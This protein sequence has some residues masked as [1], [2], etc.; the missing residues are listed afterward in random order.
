MKRGV[1]LSTLLLAATLSVTAAARQQAGGQQ[2]PRVVQVDKLRDNLY[3]M[4]GG[5]GNSSVFIT[6]SGVVVVDTKNPGWGQPLLDKI[7]SVTD[8]PVTMIINTH[9]HGDHVSGNVE[10]PAN[11]EVVTHEN[12]KKNMEAMSQPSF[13]PAPPGGVPA[14]IFKQNNGRGMPTRTYKDTLTLGR[15]AERIEL[16]YFGRAHTNGDTFVVFPEL[17]VMHAA[18]VFPNKGVPGMDS[19]NGG[20]GV[21]FAATLAKAADFADKNNIETI[22]NGHNDTPSTRA[23]LRQ[24]VQ[25]V[26]D[27]VAYAQDAKKAGK[28]VDDAVSGFKVP[29]KYSGYNAMPNAFRDKANFELIY[30]ETK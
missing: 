20:S 22:V 5:G 10:F 16:H 7:K 25:F 30:K 23:D 12:T 26:R 18:D 24:Y 17:R 3:V 21:D 11:V 4:K 19:N 2:A 27:Y 14:N 6:S 29:A 1:V 15:G 28:S 13:V 8:K 9:T